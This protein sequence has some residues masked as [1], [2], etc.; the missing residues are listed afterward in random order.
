MNLIIVFIFIV[1]FSATISYYV[2][3][4]GND[5]NN[6]GL[7][8]TA[9]ASVISAFQ[10]NASDIN[11][12]LNLGS[13]IHLV[14]TSFFIGSTVCQII[15]VNNLTSIFQTNPTVN[16]AYTFVITT[17]SLTLRLLYIIHTNLYPDPLIVLNIS[18]SSFSLESSQ[19]IITAT[20]SGPIIVMYG[21][22]VALLD[23]FIIGTELFYSFIYVV[24]K[25]TCNT[26]IDH[27]IFKNIT[28]SFPNS[29]L[30]FGIFFF[31]FFGIFFFY[32]LRKSNRVFN[33]SYY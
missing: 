20:N 13:G 5:S 18:S 4:D 9:C 33:S 12:V 6:C 3:I 28:A 25:E 15:G 26:T 8:T 14:L 22:N 1:D 23:D 32:L 31:F 11:K 24:S 7:W 16:A 2:K 27:C 29:V 21:G 30:F 19:M 10:K 17:G